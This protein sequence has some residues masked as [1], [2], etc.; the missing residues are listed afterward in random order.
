[1]YSY[2]KNLAMMYCFC[3]LYTHTR[4]SINKV[5]FASGVD[6]RKLFTVALFSR[7]SVVMGSFIS[8]KTARVDLL[9]RLWCPEIFL[10]RKVSVSTPWIIF[11]IYF[12]SGKP[13]FNS[14][15]KILLTKTCSFI[16]RYFSINF[17]WFALLSHKN[18]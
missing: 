18:W 9:Y 2:N 8:Q 1:M 3:R 4:H 10:Y 17:T 7:K 16:H 6:N 12:H 13:T 14:F 11:S 15:V 5:N